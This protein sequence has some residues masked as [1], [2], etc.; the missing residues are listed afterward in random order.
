[1]IEA[2]Q[3]LLGWAAKNERRIGAVVFVFGFI[4]DVLTFTLLP[5]NLVNIYFISFLTFAAICALGSHVL[6]NVGEG[7]SWLVRTLSVLFP[8]GAQYALG[9]LLS[10]FV[11]FYSKNA[12]VAVS[13]PFILI[14]VL[15]YIGSEYFRKYKTYLIFQTSLFFLV[16]YAYLIFA[17]PLLVHTIGPWVFAG[18][19]LAACVLFGVFLLLLRRLNQNRYLESRRNIVAA[20]A[21][22]LAVVNVAYFTELIPPLPLTLTDSGIYYTL[23]KVPGG[24]TV[25]GEPEKS[26]WDLRTAV[27]HAD[28]GD[29]L[30]AYSAV[31]APTLFGSR[32]A[33]VWE[34]KIDSD[35]I[36]M[37][38]A[39]YPIAGG[40]EGGYRGY[41]QAT[42]SPGEW[43]VTVETE[44]GQ[45]IGRVRFMVE[46]AEPESARVEKTL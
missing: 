39:S 40:R 13:W 30:Y 42:V 36:V 15:A 32:V 43:R 6:P 33:H 27:V 3:R 10:G 38:R 14:L 25:S 44:N 34:K 24:Y 8:L 31:K 9:N 17:L 18:S 1:M 16:L 5:F 45:T 37:S 29:V 28:A 20:A 7:T 46:R 11:V 2:F 41:S 19:T 12:E 35:W 22:L 4:S 23:T 26:W 21:V